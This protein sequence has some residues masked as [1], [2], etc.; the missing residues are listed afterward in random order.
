MYTKIMKSCHPA[1]MFENLQELVD[2]QPDPDNENKVPP[3]QVNEMP[4][5][6]FFNN[7]FDAR[8]SRAIFAL[9]KK[10]T[11]NPDNVQFFTTEGMIKFVAFQLLDNPP[12]GEINQEHLAD[13]DSV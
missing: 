4:V 1:E 13:E 9:T 5:R 12:D 8:L 3:I 7:T 2:P 11:Q 10:Q 6:K